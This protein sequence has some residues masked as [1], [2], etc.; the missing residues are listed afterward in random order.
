MHTIQVNAAVTHGG[1]PTHTNSGSKQITG[2]HGARVVSTGATKLKPAAQADLL[3]GLDL[4]TIAGSML[5][6]AVDAIC[7]QD[8]ATDLLEQG[9]QPAGGVLKEQVLIDVKAVVLSSAKGSVKSLLKEGL[10]A[11]LEGSTDLGG[12]MEAVCEQAADAML[13]RVVER[14]LAQGVDTFLRGSTSEQMRQGVKA[15]LRAGASKV[16]SQGFAAVVQEGAYAV[17]GLLDKGS[18]AVTAVLKGDAGAM[19]NEAF[20]LADKL[21]RRLTQL[22][23]SDKLRNRATEVLSMNIEDLEMKPPAVMEMTLLQ[24]SP[25]LKLGV[26]AV[27]TGLRSLPF[28]EVAAGVLTAFYTHAEQVRGIAS[29]E[30]GDVHIPAHSHGAAQH[31]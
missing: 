29:T 4:D 5:E 11:S 22:D 31:M 17:E 6:Q 15:A 3:S 9:S 19:I 18:A 23:S 20:G 8:T 7:K 24:Y 13:G 2:A 21:W 14:V 12:R 25:L 28:C 16:V 10:K 26:N 30:G 1:Q 27:T